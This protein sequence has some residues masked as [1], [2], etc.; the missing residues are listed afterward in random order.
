MKAFTGLVTV[1]PGTSGREYWMRTKYCWLG[2]RPVTLEDTVWVPVRARESQPGAA[3]LVHSLWSK[4]YSKR[5]LTGPPLGSML[6]EKVAVVSVLTVT[7]SRF[8]TG[9][10]S[11]APKTRT[12][13]G[14]RPVLV[15]AKKLPPTVL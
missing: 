6:A 8:T 11:G 13:K 14:V 12:L 4:E 1:E 9:A 7:G 15:E 3:T 2:V 5:H 10:G